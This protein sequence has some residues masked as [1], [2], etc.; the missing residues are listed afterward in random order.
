MRLSESQ[1][2]KLKQLLEKEELGDRQPSQFLRYLRRLAGTSVPEDLLRTIWCNRLP[3]SVQTV[4]ATQEKM[5]VEEAAI[6]ADKIYELAPQRSV[7][8]VDAN[9]GNSSLEARI[10]ELTRKVEKLSRGRVGGRRRFSRSPCKR[11]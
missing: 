6:L 1:E 5:P 7:A 11:S 8:A 2:K 10:E 3:A 9:G 4:M